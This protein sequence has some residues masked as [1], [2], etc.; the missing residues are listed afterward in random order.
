M[1]KKTVKSRPVKRANNKSNRKSS[2][3]ASI[4]FT[5]AALLFIVGSVVNLRYILTGN[6][7]I[8]VLLDIKKEN[9]RLKETNARQLRDNNELREFID[10]LRKDSQ[11]I[12]EQIRLKLNYVKKGEVLYIEEQ[13]SE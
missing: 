10:N 3:V 2:P 11:I 7:N 12:E 5:L 13:D 6:E 1:V 8:I 9:E 4:I